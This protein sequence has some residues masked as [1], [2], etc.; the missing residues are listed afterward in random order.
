[1][2][3]LVRVLSNPEAHTTANGGQNCCAGSRLFLHQDIYDAFIG[4]LKARLGKIK[5]GLPSKEDT[6]LGAL[7]IFCKIS[8]LVDQNQ[9]EKVTGFITRALDQGIPTLTE[10]TPAKEGYFVPPTGMPNWLSNIDN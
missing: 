4:K 9:F 5:M 2:Q 1:M 10:Y 3:P 7:G 8:Y 6:D